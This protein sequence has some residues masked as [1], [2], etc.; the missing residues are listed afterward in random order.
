[1]ETHLSFFWP[2]P[3][4]ISGVTMVSPSQ[5]SPS[6]VIPLGT[7]L[8]HLVPKHLGGPHGLGLSNPTS[9]LRPALPMALKTDNN[10]RKQGPPPLLHP[11]PDILKRFLYDNIYMTTFMWEL[12]M[13]TNHNKPRYYMKKVSKFNCVL[14]PFLPTVP[15]MEHSILAKIAKKS[16]KNGLNSQ[17]FEKN[18]FTMKR[19]D[20]LLK[21]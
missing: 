9:F 3:V 13:T 16:G 12:Y 8:H 4:T 17:L 19:S 14:N 2:Y 21:E 10:A 6:Q 20:H 11:N 1:M 5:V 18:V 7:S 15:Q